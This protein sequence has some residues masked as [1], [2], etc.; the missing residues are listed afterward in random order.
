MSASIHNRRGQPKS[1]KIDDLS[2]SPSEKQ[3]LSPTVSTHTKMSPPPRPQADDYFGSKRTK[4]KRQSRI[5]R[6]CPTP[7]FQSEDT[8]SGEASFGPSTEPGSSKRQNVESSSDHIDNADFLS[9]SDTPPLAKTAAESQD[10]TD[11]WEEQSND[12]SAASYRP[13]LNH[14]TPS[15]QDDSYDSYDP[16]DSPA[17]NSLRRISQSMTHS[18]DSKRREFKHL[19]KTLADKLNTTF[20]SKGKSPSGHVNRDTDRGNVFGLHKAFTDP[21]PLMDNASG[22]LSPTSKVNNARAAGLRVPAFITLRKASGVDSFRGTT[23]VK[24]PSSLDSNTIQNNQP[25]ATSTATSNLVSIQSQLEHCAAKSAWQAD[26]KLAK[27]STSPMSSSS[28]DEKP[29]VRARFMSLSQLE[30]SAPSQRYTAAAEPVLTVTSFYPTRAAPLKPQSRSNSVSLERAPLRF[31]V[32]QIVSRNSVHEIIWYED[33]TSASDSS[34][35][36]SPK[37]D[38]RASDE[39]V[40]QVISDSGGQ[41]TPL[42]AITTS[43]TEMDVLPQVNDHAPKESLPTATDAHKGLLSWSWENLQPSIA[44]FSS[45]SK[46][47][48]EARGV[49]ERTSNVSMRGADTAEMLTTGY[50]PH[51]ERQDSMPTEEDGNEEFM[52]KPRTET[53][54]E[55]GMPKPL[56]RGLAMFQRRG[57]SLGS[58][59]SRHVGSQSFGEKNGLKSSGSLLRVNTE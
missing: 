28:Y 2:A 46:E 8:G 29:Y 10:E 12:E 19:S 20:R 39:T 58:V 17:V 22:D 53:K 56:D 4:K 26:P 41:E 35:P 31:S 13:M 11:R 23:N 45:P 34:S 55:S 52:A 14:G 27:R 43:P 25:P 57:I 49:G 7:L 30:N 3:F 33:E 15:N 38:L 50:F 54:K 51:L 44:D 32:V 6:P 24:N 18:S 40:P 42:I 5:R 47:S 36:T 9:K 1:L 59:P 48:N 16:H 37:N 21:S